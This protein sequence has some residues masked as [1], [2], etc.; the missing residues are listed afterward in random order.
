[1]KVINIHRLL[2]VCLANAVINAENVEMNP[3]EEKTLAIA[4]TTI[5]KKEWEKILLSRETK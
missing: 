3:V 5:G 4:K 1:M 2:P